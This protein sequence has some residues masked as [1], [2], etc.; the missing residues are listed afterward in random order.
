M[1][2]LLTGATKG[3]G[4]EIC[5]ALLASGASV[6][7]VSRERTALFAI[8]EKEYPKKLFFL[9]ADLSEPKEAVQKIFSK[10]FICNEIKLD[11]FVNNAAIAYDD[12]VS[13][14]DFAKLETMF[15]VNTFAPMLLTKYAIRN[16]IF[17]STKGSIVHIS[18]V[19][20][21]TGYKGLAM[22]AASKGA[23]EAFSKNTAREWGEKGIRSN[24]IVAGFMDTDMSASLDAEKR[25]RIYNR[26]AL[27]L[28]TNLESVAHTVE[29]LVSQ[30]S[31]S[32]TGQNIFVD[33]GT[34]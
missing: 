18:S 13:N 20:V 14:I 10:D 27:K 4:F 15:K 1:N 12:I 3:L 30:K 2:I 11:A 32:I 7:A 28:P 19:S 22:Y 5:K 9:S 31:A 33:S 25:Q 6:Y 34:I 8:L 26:T 23:V 16:M 21:H 29:F 24:C 17:N